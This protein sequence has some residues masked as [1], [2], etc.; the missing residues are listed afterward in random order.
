MKSERRQSAK[1]SKQ[2]RTWCSR[3]VAVTREAAVLKDTEEE[4]GPA[5]AAAALALVEEDKREK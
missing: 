5:K 4:E 2:I 1:Y 3:Y